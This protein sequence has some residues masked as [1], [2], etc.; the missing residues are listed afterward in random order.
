MFQWSGITL[1][2][3][4]KLTVSNSVKAKDLTIKA[5]NIAEIQQWDSAQY[6]L[7]SAAKLYAGAKA[8]K[9]C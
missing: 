9:N 1:S 8:G 6:S 3:G 4:Q 5:Q 7:H 2:Y